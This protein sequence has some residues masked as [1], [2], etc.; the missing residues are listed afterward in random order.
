M[1]NPDAEKLFEVLDATWPA[2]RFVVHGPWSLREGLGGGQRVSAATVLADFDLN[3]ISSAE[4]A[5]HDLGQ[6]PL[7]MV[8]SKDEDL[9]RQLEA[10]GY[11]VVDPVCI[12]VAQVN[13]MKKNLQLTAAMPSWPPLAI[14]KELWEGGGIGP[15]RLAVMDRAAGPKTTLLGRSDDEPCGTVFV[16]ASDG[17]AMLHALEVAPKFRRKGVGRNL[18]HEAANWAAEHGAEWVSLA[19]TKENKSAN[20]LYG[21]LG[22]R[23]AAEYHYRRATSETK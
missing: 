6:H 20:Q 2:A 10:R 23:P 12:Y 16:A 17:I 14:Q 18:M 11:S 15:E 4:R 21:K 5:M 22:M 1:N 3:D 13:D 9:D 7:F 8:R 19:V